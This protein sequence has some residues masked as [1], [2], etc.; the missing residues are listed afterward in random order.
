MRTKADALALLHKAAA[1]EGD[2]VRVVR[3]V[4]ALVELACLLEG[5]LRRAG[6][7]GP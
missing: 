5:N 7:N 4:C 3:G 1:D 6:S 2:A